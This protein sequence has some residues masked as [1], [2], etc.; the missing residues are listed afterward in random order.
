[1]VSRAVHL[2][3]AYGLDTYSFLN[4]FSGMVNRRR[5][6]EVVSDN[7]TNFVSSE[8]ELRELVEAID[9]DK[10]H[11]SAADKGIKWHFN[12][13]LAPHF[14]G[15]HE[16]MVKSAK[17]AI[18]AILGNANISDEKMTT[19]FTELK[20]FLNSRSLTYQ[21]AN[22]ED[23]LPLTPNHFLYDQQGRTFAPSL[24][25]ETSFSHKK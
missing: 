20:N 9:K 13:P 12:P 3:V 2:E 11:R 24:V 4:A 7:G 10:I 19:V 1:M 14:G 21:I 23:N 16:S 22:P 6:P 15:I 18:K 25:D 8:R 17:C 5:V